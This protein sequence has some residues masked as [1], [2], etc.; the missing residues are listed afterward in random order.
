MFGLGTEPGSGAAIGGGSSGARS[1]P[2]D[3]VRGGEPDRDHARGAVGGDPLDAG[4]LEGTLDAVAQPVA[5]PGRVAGDLQGGDL[6]L[7]AAA[8]AGVLVGRG[9]PLDEERQLR[10]G[11]Q[12]LDADLPPAQL[13]AVGA[14]PVALDGLAPEPALDLADVVDRD[15]PA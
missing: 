15:H 12:A 14:V 11:L 10:V 13:D 2:D 4:L 7:A 3:T 5:D 8:L 1:D 9:L 6:H